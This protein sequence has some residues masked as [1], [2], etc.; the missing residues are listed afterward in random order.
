MEAIQNTGRIEISKDKEHS[1]GLWN[2]TDLKTL[3][4]KLAQ[5]KIH[6]K[7]ERVVNLKG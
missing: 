5:E 3:S 7:C 6:V 1:R 4:R 2:K